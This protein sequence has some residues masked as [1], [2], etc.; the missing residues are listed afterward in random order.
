MDNK[1]NIEGM[2]FENNEIV[3]EIVDAC[4][5]ADVSSGG[6]WVGKLVI[7]G[8][9]ITAATAVIFRKQ[10]GAAITAR[11]IKKLEKKGYVIAHESEMMD[12]EEE[13]SENINVEDEAENY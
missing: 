13:T 1:M 8:M 3:E 4:E 9:V 5:N 7:A 2:N 11:N 12:C 6:N 10:I